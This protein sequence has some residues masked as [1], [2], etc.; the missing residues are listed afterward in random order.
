M[1]ALMRHKLHEKHMK[2]ESANGLQLSQLVESCLRELSCIHYSYS[3]IIFERLAW[4]L[5]WLKLLQFASNM[6]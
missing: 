3:L 1:E 2:L 5:L 4:K 6:L